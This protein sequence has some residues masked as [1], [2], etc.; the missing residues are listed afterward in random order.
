MND[1]IFNNNS[2]RKEEVLFHK[3]NPAPFIGHVRI[4]NPVTV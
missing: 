1:V 3:N 4:V 2:W